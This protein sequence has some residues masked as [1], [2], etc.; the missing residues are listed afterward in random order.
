MKSIIGP[1]VVAIVL[2]L[3]ASGFWLAGA[4]ETRL[5]DAHKQLVTLQYAEAA[6]AGDDVARDIGLERR[7]DS[8]GESYCHRCGTR[9]IAVVGRR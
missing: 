8:R 1:L 4:T 3:V 2:A 7:V 6:A 9:R 5:A